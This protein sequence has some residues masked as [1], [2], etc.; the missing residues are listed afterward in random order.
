[1]QFR[2]CKHVILFNAIGLP[3][4]SVGHIIFQFSLLLLFET[5]SHCDKY[6]TICSLDNSRCTC[7]PSWSVVVTFVS[8]TWRSKWLAHFSKNSSVS[9]F[10]KIHPAILEL[11]SC[12]RTDGLS[13]FN[14]CST[15]LRTHLKINTPTMFVYL[16]PTF[17]GVS[18]TKIVK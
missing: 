16:K 14:T 7:R 12:L 2:N 18:T 5:F 6:L 13:E 9:N 4:M 17:R 15:E 10:N 3:K 11:I 8:S 1:M